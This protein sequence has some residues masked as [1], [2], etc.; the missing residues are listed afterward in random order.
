MW[1]GTRVSARPPGWPW[2]SGL[3]T[4][5]PPQYLPYFASVPRDVALFTTQNRQPAATLAGWDA[6][7]ALALASPRVTSYRSDRHAPPFALHVGVATL[8]VPQ[9]ASSRRH[10]CWVQA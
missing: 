10:H 2:W 6:A 8:P 3:S 9:P 7:W 5:E 1:A 4:R